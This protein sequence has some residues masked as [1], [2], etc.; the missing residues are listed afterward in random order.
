MDSKFLRVTL[1]VSILFM[2]TV[3]FFF[4]SIVLETQGYNRGVIVI[5]TYFL[6]YWACQVVLGVRNPPASA[7]D[8]VDTGLIPGLGKSPG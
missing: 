2:V 8:T 3:F 4:K 5:K 7:G 6:W 1:L